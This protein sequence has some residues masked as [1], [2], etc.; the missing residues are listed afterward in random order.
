MGTSASGEGEAPSAPASDDPVSHPRRSKQALSRQRQ[1]DQLRDYLGKGTRDTAANMAWASREEEKYTAIHAR[2]GKAYGC[3]CKGVQSKKRP[4]L[5]CTG[6]ERYFHVACERL[7]LRPGD[8]AKLADAYLCSGCEREQLEKEGLSGAQAEAYECRFCAK[9]FTT[10]RGVLMHAVRCRQRPVERTWS[11]PCRGSKTASGGTECA[12]CTNW[13]HKKCR[14]ELRPEWMAEDGDGI[15][16][17]AEADTLCDA[18]LCLRRE[19][20]SG[21]K[22]VLGRRA[23][24][25]IASAQ[26]LLGAE[27]SHELAASQ[28]FGTLR[29][30]DVFVSESTIPG[31]GLGLFAGR[32]FDAGEFITAYSGDL[33]YKVRAH[34]P[35]RSTARVGRLR[36]ARAPGGA[37]QTEVRASG[38]VDES[39]MLR[40]PG[41]GDQVI[42]GSHFARALRANGANPRDDGRYEPLPDAPEWTMGAAAMA[43]DPRG[44]RANNARLCFRTPRGGHHRDLLL[45]APRRGY[46]CATQRIAEVPRCF[47]PWRAAFALGSPARGA[48]RALR[49]STTTARTSPSEAWTA[50]TATRRRTR[51][52][53]ASGHSRSSP[54]RALRPPSR[55]RSSASGRRD[56]RSSPPTE[57]CEPWPGVPGPRPRLRARARAL[58]CSP[59]IRRRWP[60]TPHRQAAE[61]LRNPP[62]RLLRQHGR[63]ESVTS[64]RRSTD[65]S[66]GFMPGGELAHRRGRKV[67]APRETLPCAHRI[68]TVLRGEQGANA[69]TRDHRPWKRACVH[70]LSSRA[71]TECS[72]F[73]L[74]V[75][76]CLHACMPP[77]RTCA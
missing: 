7:W 50:S 53:G 13:F 74:G 37:S 10:E 14:K 4:E 1:L 20:A 12:T 25:P 63:S 26:R 23:A 75:I 8:M 38:R 60:R 6:C 34:C 71:T 9:I 11:C 33:L 46:L 21:K 45:L 72:R 68:L 40:I 27:A 28:E 18:C 70:D 5:W 3:A 73:A 16:P 41:S 61:Y 59:Q 69:S 54:R 66:P 39:Y 43:N 22:D 32:A 67:V 58:H 24:R 35:G 48:R 31:A 65:P 29:N 52:S 36:A 49:F 55:A 62:P 19:Q 44:A 17:A 2:E 47:R 42:D 56:S 57:P 77:P 64:G 15:V 30:G 51:Q 76:H